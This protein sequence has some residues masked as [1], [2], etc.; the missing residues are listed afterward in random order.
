M[1]NDR[2]RTWATLCTDVSNVVHAR[3][4]ATLCTDVCDVV[5]TRVWNV[6]FTRVPG[7]RRDCAPPGTEHRDKMINKRIIT[8]IIR[9]L[10]NYDGDL[11]RNVVRRHARVR[12]TPLHV[13][14]VPDGTYNANRLARQTGAGE[15]VQ[16]RLGRLRSVAIART[17]IAYIYACACW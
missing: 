13:V 15:V 12:Y 16:V 10:G 5:F 14:V 2:T 9:T 7:H 4:R 8:I 11:C 6:V 17:Y 3:T 1:N